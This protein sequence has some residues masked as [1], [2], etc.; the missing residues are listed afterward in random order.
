VP[1]VVR[2]RFRRAKPMPPKGHDIYRSKSL[3]RLSSPDAVDQLLHVVRARDWIALLAAGMLIAALLAWSITGTIP[4]TVSG[5]SVL[6]LP[7]TI[8]DVQTLSSGRLES[9]RI[10]PGD[11]VKKG[12]VL[13]LIDQSEIRKGVTEDRNMLEELRQQDRIQAA[14]R[15]RQT[16]LQNEQIQS[17]RNFMQLQID[18]LKKSLQDA[19]TMAPMLKR[20]VEG[21]RTLR[22]QGLIADAS[23]E[24]LQAED[25]LLQNDTKMS[26]LNARLNQFDAQVKEQEMRRA[27]T[28]RDNLESSTVRGNRIKDLT[29]KIALAEL[30]LSNNSEIRNE[31]TGRIIE[32]IGTPGQVMTSGARIATIQIEDPEQTLES[33]SYFNVADGKKIQRGMEVQVTPDPVER[34]RFGGITGVVESVSELPVTKEAALLVV[35]NPSTVDLLMP[36]GPFI[37]VT[38]RLHR[39]AST[40]SGFRWSSS[41]GPSMQISP[42][43]TATGR[44]T[45]EGRAPIT[46]I[47]P[48][49][50]SVSG[51]Y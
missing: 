23:A 6:V 21:L 7:Q 27:S 32:V 2:S 16:G 51:I 24:L 41:A 13:G 37:Q 35:G 15:E 18:T 14:L 46:Y 47:F 45:V 5:R 28:E 1:F 29:T 44:V 4:T 19:Q 12:D 8:V 34:Q 50:R 30:Q 33:V 20:R 39:D 10:K 36:S 48:F 25:A 22:A 43:V 3:E 11:F 17:E 42:G 49:L 31:H 38:A 26:D 40:F 9:L